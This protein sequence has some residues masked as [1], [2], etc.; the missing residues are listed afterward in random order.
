MKKI[1]ISITVKAPIKK[2]WEYWNSPHHIS[3]WAFASDDW[4]AEGKEN[5]LK[6]GGKFRTTMS[7]KDKK[8]RFDFEGFYTKVEKYKTIEFEMSDGRHV[9]IHFKDAPEG[10]EITET[11]DPEEENPHDMQRKGWQAILNNFKKYA[12]R[13]SK[14]R[15][16]S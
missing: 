9:A 13:N 12:E 14:E 11:F 7:S 6:V 4:M 5:E 8:N 15:R 2:V 3:G 10:I 1:T 16:E